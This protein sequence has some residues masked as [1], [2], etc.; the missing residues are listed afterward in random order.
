MSGIRYIIIITLLISFS[1][2]EKNT[3]NNEQL[4][5][6]SE[7]WKFSEYK[8]DKFYPAEI[9]GVVHTDLL[10]NGL[11]E[12][13]FYGDNEM[14]YQWIG[15]K[16]WEYQ[17]NFDVEESVIENDHLDLI[18]EGIDTYS[19]VYLNDSLI[20]KT[21][22]MFLEW[23]A[24]VKKLL[25]SKNNILRIIF[26]PVENEMNSLAAKS[27]YQLPDKR[28]YVRKAPF[29]FGWDWGPKFLTAGIWKPVKINAWHDYRIEDIQIIP[30]IENSS[31]CNVKVNIEIESDVNQKVDLT[32]SFKDSTFLLVNKS[33]ELKKG[34][35]TCSA[36]FI[37][38]DPELWWCNGYGNP[39]LYE[40]VC[41]LSENEVVKTTRSQKFG[42]REIELINEKDSAG[43]SFY[44][45]LNGIP[46]FCKGANYIPQD[47]FLPGITEDENLELLNDV[48]ES[49][50]NMIR[51]WG[52]GVYETD[53]FYDICDS[54]GIMIWQDFMFA[55]TIYPGT[56]TFLENVKIEFVQQIVR[57]RNHPSIVLW[58]GN[59]EIKNGWF[60]WGWQKQF[61][62]SKE[63]SAEIWN[64]YL[65][66]FENILP[67]CIN[68][69]DPTRYYWPSSPEY[70]WGHPE[71]LTHGDS[72]YWGVWWGMEPFDNYRNKTGR[73][74]SEYGFQAFPDLKTF[75]DFTKQEYLFIESDHLKSHQK[76]PTGYETI[77]EYMD[78]DY[79]K[80]K[81]FQKLIY[82]SQLLQAEGVKMAI[83]S[84]R[85]KKPYCMGTLYWQLNDCWP[86]V[87]WSGIDYKGRWKAFQYYVKKLYHEYLIVP[88]YKDKQMSLNVV[89]D[90][91]KERNLSLI[92]VEMNFNGD[93]ISSKKADFNIKANQNA[94]VL[95]FY[96]EILSDIDYRNVLIHSALLDG[97]S[98]LTEDYYYFVRPNQLVLPDPEIK[99]EIEETSQGYIIIFTSKALAKNIYISNSLI[100]EDS[101]SDNYFDL[102]PGE[103]KIIVCCAS[104]RSDKIR[105]NFHCM[106]LYDCLNK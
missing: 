33:I 19:D 78:R 57:L 15:E 18:F 53:N 98:M 80:T 66:L 17:L 77:L 51:V 1:C 93:T 25:K 2:S 26:F 103:K 68:R 90:C 72:H 9:P 27:N 23:S 11:I 43:Q 61:K 62:Y 59:N 85:A 36:D 106:T 84:H 81:D 46:V 73:F 64:N 82:L 65:N 4:I 28:A 29:Q 95:K 75:L 56:D 58:C 31:N 16:T 24:D 60:D 105:N 96:P 97:D 99:I 102:L 38:N 89:S 14:K 47:V 79:I 34:M 37:V 52:G 55:C 41:S 44:F 49:N 50:M 92:V 83:V 88:E 76:H 20:F 71:N 87:S 63:D 91:Q 13:P 54:L 6:L 94:T 48:K 69:L 100:K 104:E 40:I 5:E 45:K 8:K 39:A 21:N 10:N 101:Y 67:D 30:N 12:D 86:V 35:S 32:I 70:G 74:M 7:N 42:I 3:K 22:N